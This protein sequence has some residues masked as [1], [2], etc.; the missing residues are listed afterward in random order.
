MNTR[1][2][3]L[4]A[5]FLAFESDRTPTHVGSVAFFEGAPFHDEDGRFRL[6]ELRS[7]V[8]SRLHL[9]PRLRQRPTDTPLG[10]A[11][12]LLVDD[13]QFDIAHHVRLVEIGAPATETEVF[14][15]AATLHMERLDPHRP[16]W[17]L[18]FVEGLADGRVALVEKIHHSIVDGVSGVEV[19]T[20]LLDLERDPAPSAAPPWDPPDP[21]STLDLT[22][23]GLADRLQQPVDLLEDLLGG[24][25]HPLDSVAHVAH[26]AAALRSFLR[27]AHRAPRTSL[28]V[29]VGHRRRLAAVRRPLAT[30]K[31]H[32]H[33]HGGTVN[34]LVLAAVTTGLRRLLAARG[35]LPADPAFTLKALVPVSLHTTEGELGNIVAGLIVDL[36]VGV[37]EPVARI[38]SISADLREHKSSG[39]AA[40]QAG[41]MRA[42]DLLPPTVARS[43]SRA[44]HHQPFVNVVVT[45]VPGTSFPLYSMGAQLLDAV[46]IV[47]LGGNLTVSIGV[48]SY[49]GSLDLGILA[50]A[51]ACPDLDVLVDGIEEGFDELARRPST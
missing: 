5:A 21:P 50:D 46:P 32:A 16:L 14:E 11:H 27:P 8:E 42:A 20:V 40:A 39:E 2:T 33:G 12:P 34:D 3:A 15:L 7:R 47:P 9:V 38:R 49:D 25:R 31:E 30:V 6:A 43:L 19:A 1:L 24:L 13:P 4:D 23:A 22:A 35:E 26:D 45:N 28:N 37:A 44:V 29:Q 10:I 17:E 51:D 36:P 18:W 48:L 41:L